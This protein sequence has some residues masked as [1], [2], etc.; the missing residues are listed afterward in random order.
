MSVVVALLCGELLVRYV[1]PQKLYRFPKG[2]FEN[3]PSLQYKLT[4]NFRGIVKTLEY[5]TS[6]RINALGLR[7]DREYG[8]KPPGTYRILAIGDSFT[9]GVNVE[10]EDTYVKVLER[11]LESGSDGQTYEVINAGVP[12]YNTRQE[13]TYLREEGF[14]LEPGEP[15]YR[16][17]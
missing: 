10:L 6:I 17:Q 9:M 16:T 2:M 3:H 12:G 5:K 8:R 7:E 11:L 1:A 13:L 4:P 14:K 15:E